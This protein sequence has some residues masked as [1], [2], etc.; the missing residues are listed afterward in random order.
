[1]LA[2]MDKI[3][4]PVRPAPGA[5]AVSAVVP[6]DDISYTPTRTPTVADLDY[7]DEQAQYQQERD[8]EMDW[9]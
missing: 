1:M 8:N 4:F 2:E 6:T 9:D 7:E 3:T 5:T